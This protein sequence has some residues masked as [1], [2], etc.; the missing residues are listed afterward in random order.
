MDGYQQA[1]PPEGDPTA[2][3]T[4]ANPWPEEDTVGNLYEHEKVIGVG[5][6]GTVYK[7]RHRETD[8]V[9]AIKKLRI[10]EDFGQGVPSHVLREIGLLVDFKHPN[11]VELLDVHTTSP[12]DYSLVFEFVDGDLHHLLKS[13][14]KSE[15]T[16]P[17]ELA[18]HY[19]YDLLNGLHACHVRLILHRDLKPQNVLIGR[20][21]LKIG[22]FGLSRLYS[23]PIRSYTLDVVTLW[24]RAPE[25]LLGC[26]R[27][28]PEVDI[29]SAGCIIAEMLVGGPIFPG[30]S[31]IGTIFKI[32]KACGTPTE[33]SW[34]ELSQLDNWRPTFPKWPDTKLEGVI[35]SRPEMGTDGA[36]LLRSL[37]AMNPQVR[38]SARRA[39]ASAFAQVAPQPS[40]EP[41]KKVEMPVLPS[42]E[43][44]DAAAAQLAAQLA[45]QPPPESLVSSAA[46]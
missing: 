34:P 22:D 8:R 46:A 43:A 32:F 27:Y 29:W 39:R 18:R 24:Y 11:I 16:I 40:R 23:L 7:G 1:N 26:Q 3:P 37:L 38:S 10:E 19:A 41:A 44:C 12:Y 5:V 17:M 28:G 6:Y 4:G 13:Y 25:I 45:A 35:S 2:A 33:E 21:G 9:V 36:D 31:E 15:I 20:N 14:R 30:D 42:E